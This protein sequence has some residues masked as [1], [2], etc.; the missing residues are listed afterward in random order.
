MNFLNSVEKDLHNLNPRLVRPITDVKDFW[1]AMSQYIN[2]TEKI[3]F[4]QKN[5]KISLQMALFF[6]EA[7]SISFRYKKWMWEIIPKDPNLDELTGAS[8][9]KILEEFCK[10]N[11]IKA[12]PEKYVAITKDEY[13][14]KHSELIEKEQS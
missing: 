14:K 13:I 12:L 7:F 8:T 2:I 3:A 11:N 4:L 1:L 9:G 5:D 6:Q 10:Q